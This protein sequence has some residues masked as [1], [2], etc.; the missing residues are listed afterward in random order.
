[1]SPLVNATSSSISQ[2]L[3]KSQAHRKR[4]LQ[5]FHPLGGKT[6]LTTLDAICR[7]IQESSPGNDTAIVTVVRSKIPLPLVARYCW[8]GS[9]GLET[10]LRSLEYSSLSTCKDWIGIRAGER[11]RPDRLYLISPTWK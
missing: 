9:G 5:R 1:M 2:P 8:R 7:R 4:H 6:K 11:S 3:R 10:P